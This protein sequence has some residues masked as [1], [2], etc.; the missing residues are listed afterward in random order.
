[1]QV[2]ARKRLLKRAI[3]VVIESG[4]KWV[5]VVVVWEEGDCLRLVTSFFSLRED[6]INFY[7]IEF[8]AEE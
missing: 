5:V 4:C 3:T 1:M 8:V 7:K 2:V 6:L